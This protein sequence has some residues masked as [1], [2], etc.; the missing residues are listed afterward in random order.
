MRDPFDKIEAACAAETFAARARRRAGRARFGAGGLCC[1]RTFFGFGLRGGL[2]FGGVALFC[3]LF[4][5]TRFGFSL[6]CGLSF[7][8]VALFCSLFGSSTRFGFSLRCGLSFGGAAVFCSLFG[9]TRFCFSLRCG[10]SFGGAALFCSL[11]G[12]T[13]FGFSL[14]CG[15]SFGGAALFCSLFGGTRSGFSL[16]SG[17]S[18]GSAALFYSFFGSTRFGFSLRN[19][20]RFGR[21]AYLGLTRRIRIGAFQIRRRQRRKIKPACPAKA[22]TADPFGRALRTYRRRRR[23]GL[24]IHESLRNSR[25]SHTDRQIRRRSRHLQRSTNF[26]FH[27]LRVRGRLRSDGSLGT[28]WHRRAALFAKPGSRAIGQSAFLTTHARS[29]GS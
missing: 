11:F 5:S 8:G 26:R 24:R 6:R 9:G 29:Q 17:L 19:S 10:L 3:S 23:H 21:T 27:S 12:S 28:A 1:G 16:R 14:R 4:G 2:S 22:L 25:R 15:L 20:L 7:G 13:R 18:F